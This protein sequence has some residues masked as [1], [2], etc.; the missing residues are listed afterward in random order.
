MSK[1]KDIWNQIT[2]ALQSKLP[3]SEFETWFSKTSL[4]AFDGKSALISVPNKFVAGWLT[5]KYL[6][7][8]EDSFKRVLK[9]SPLL[10]FSYDQ[11]VPSGALVDEGLGE[12]REVSTQQG[13]DPSMTFELYLKGDWNQFAY[14]SAFEIADRI[15]SPYNPLYIHA[16]S[17]LGKTHLLH[18][19]G[20]RRISIEPHAS[21]AYIS[22]NTFTWQ[23]TQSWRSDNLRSFRDQYCALDLLLFDDV[24]LLSTRPKMQEEFLIIFDTLC[25]ENKKVVITADKPPYDL[26]NMNSRLRSRLGSG[27]I[28]SI[29]TPDQNALIPIIRSR[30][31][32]DGVHIPDD[33]VF[34]LSITSKDLKTLLKNIT[35]LETY[36]SLTDGDI[37]MSIAKSLIKGAEQ[38]GIGLEDI[39][40]IIAGYFNISV[41]DLTSK[42]KKR[43]H[44]YPRQLAMY[45]A[46]KYTDLSF[47]EIGESFGHKDHSTVMYAIKR[48]E[49]SKEMYDLKKIENLLG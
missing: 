21:V 13:P 38:K 7:H 39:K 43:T 19:T 41:S 46:R 16:L 48:V 1:K 22:S 30:A 27:L 25:A 8:I 35:R 47:R 45:L 26:K 4:I 36:A 34:F 11:G 2:K 12:S 23:F 37:N 32:K 40:S 14:S 17:G 28:A 33:I 20:N 9:R 24:H 31:Q 44:S 49:K 10:Q 42:K 6:T 18:A 15:S 29:Q 5:E 3:A